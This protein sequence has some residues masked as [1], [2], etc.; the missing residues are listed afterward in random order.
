MTP[1][2]SLDMDRLARAF[3]AL[4]DRTRLEIVTML[5]DGERCVCELTQVVGS[6]QS[7][8]SF[9]LKIL[10]EAGLVTT[11]RCGKWVYYS[12]DHGTL[13]SLRDAVATVTQPAIHIGACC[14]ES[15]CCHP[16]SKPI[17]A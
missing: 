14:R 4:S 3:H 5:T 11:R 17:Q 10:R 2:T 7:L 15:L 8:L 1:M 13:K 16:D 9:H 6:R 12:L